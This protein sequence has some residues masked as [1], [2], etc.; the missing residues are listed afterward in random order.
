MILEELEKELVSLNKKSENL[1][2]EYVTL[3]DQIQN[4][5]K[6]INKLK[7][8]RANIG[9]ELS[10][11]NHR[12]L[13][14]EE[15]IYDLTQGDI[16]DQF[17][18]D[19]MKASCFCERG[20]TTNLNYV[21]ISNNEMFACDGFKAIRI[22]SDNIPNKLKNTYI[23][24]DSKRFFAKNIEKEIR[25][26]NINF[27][28][29]IKN[30]MENYIYKIRTDNN[31]FY[32]VFNI[33][34]TSSNDANIMILNDYISLNQKYLEI[35]LNTFDKLENF[36]VYIVN[37]LREILLVNNRISIIILPMLLHKNED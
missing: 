15:N 4:L 2:L 30:L 18:K 19:F 21:K 22:K 23:K 13:T 35:A 5:E 9:L 20:Y 16:N 28:Q 3:N 31:D 1:K 34:Y 10:N 25:Y 7:Y 17:L 12:I 29:I 24:W 26:P 37:K 8:K 32:K 33:E 27:E 11:I 36:D 14:V 6:E